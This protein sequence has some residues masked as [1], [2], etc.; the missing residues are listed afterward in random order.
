MAGERSQGDH[1][2]WEPLLT[3]VGDVLVGEFMWMFEIELADGAAVH[4]YKHI[5]TRRYLHIAEDGRTLVYTTTGR[6]RPID[7]YE[8]LA[9]AFHEWELV[10]GDREGL[11]VLRTELQAAYRKAAGA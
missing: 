8:A 5:F 6:Y 7:R 3:L 9:L 1:P 10:G 11:D 4:A 2:T